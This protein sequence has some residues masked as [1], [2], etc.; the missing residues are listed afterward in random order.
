MVKLEYNKQ[1]VNVP[2]SWA[3]VTLGVYETIY[4]LKPESHRDRVAMVALACQV[5][6]DILLN[7]PAEIF[8]TIVSYLGFIFGDNPETARPYIETPSQRYVIAIEEALTLGEWI[9]A[10]EVQKAGQGVISG[11]LAI[12]CRPAGEAYDP[13]V[14]DARR[15]MFKALPMSEVLGAMAFFLRCSQILE[16]HTKTSIRL[17][18]LVALLP[19]S[20][21]PTLRPGGGIKLSQIFAAARYW[22]LTELLHYQL[23]KY[24]RSYNSRSTKKLRTMRSAN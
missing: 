2:E 24:L 12:V 20:I 4:F 8:N 7:W 22:I 15:D 5:E 19:R 13:I 1:S 18:E 14:T 23:R 21:K 9:D 11:V 6:A 17:Q 10:E 16:K 3:D